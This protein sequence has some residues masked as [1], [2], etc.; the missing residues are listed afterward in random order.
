MKGSKE[1]NN[2][3]KYIPMEKKKNERTN[4]EK[5]QIDKYR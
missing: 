2:E 1:K 5:K 4:T 3:K